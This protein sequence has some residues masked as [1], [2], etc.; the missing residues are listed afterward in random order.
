VAHLRGPFAPFALRPAPPAAAACLLRGRAPS[1][2]LPGLLLLLLPLPPPLLPPPLS[3]LALA[4]TVGP[5]CAVLQA[6][7]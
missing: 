6:G 5:T 2:S 7:F 4:L 1:L 3:P